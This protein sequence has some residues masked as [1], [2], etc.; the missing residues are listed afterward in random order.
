MFALLLILI[1]I[2]PPW[3]VWTGYVINLIVKI[4]ISDIQKG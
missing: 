1:Y 4:A 2:N 3:W